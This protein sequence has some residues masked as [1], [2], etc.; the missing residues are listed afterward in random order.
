MVGKVDMLLVVYK[1][2]NKG[3]KGP[4]IKHGKR[5]QKGKKED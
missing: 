4:G 1:E 3:R 2:K 5:Q